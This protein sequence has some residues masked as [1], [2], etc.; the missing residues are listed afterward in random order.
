MITYNFEELFTWE[1]VNNCN[2]LYKDCAIQIAVKNDKILL[3]ESEHKE[4]EIILV[5]VFG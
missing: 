4:K 2:F 5:S 1:I 3:A